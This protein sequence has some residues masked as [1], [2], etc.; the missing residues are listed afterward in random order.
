MPF[1]HETNIPEFQHAEVIESPDGRRYQTPEGLLYPSVTT[2]L[3]HGQDM[4]WKDAWI[5]RVGQAEAD[6]VS[7]QATTR[8]TAVHDLLEKYLDNDPGYLK[9]HMPANIH[10]A[11]KLFPALDE[12]LSKVIRQETPLY[13]DKLRTAGRVDVVGEWNG[14][15]SII[16]FKTSKKYKKKSDI[17][18]YFMQASFYAY[19][20][21]ERT[22]QP[23]PQ[24]VILIMVDEGSHQ[25]FVE[26]TMDWLPKFVELRNKVPL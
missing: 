17:E 24:I 21:F 11:K 5:A 6:K 20:W 4:S 13:S 10:T 25:I 26:K 23:V 14:I 16:D 7:R 18:G 12:H 15:R 19:A 8:G 1:L 3:G 22:G 2:V 9:G